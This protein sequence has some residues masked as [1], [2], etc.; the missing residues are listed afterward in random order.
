MCQW[1]CGLK[2]LIGN[3]FYKHFTIWKCIFACFYVAV[4]PISKGGIGQVSGLF[5]VCLVSPYAFFCSVHSKSFTIMHN[6]EWG[7]SY[8]LKHW[9][10]HLCSAVGFFN[11]NTQLRFQLVSISYNKSLSEA[12]ISVGLILSFNQ[13]DSLMNIMVLDFSFCWVNQS[14]KKMLVLWT[15][16]TIEA[17]LK[18]YHILTHVCDCIPFQL[19]ARRTTQKCSLQR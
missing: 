4:R 14:P 15:S 6:N 1:L 17:N 12:T 13:V 19:M 10:F 2:L 16:C 5:Q 7:G 3:T 9:S 11:I 8:V 18:V